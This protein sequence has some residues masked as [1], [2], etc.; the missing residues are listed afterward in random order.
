M[1]QPSAQRAVKKDLRIALLNRI[2]DRSHRIRIVLLDRQ[3]QDRD[4]RRQR[5]GIGIKIPNQQLRPHASLLRVLI[6]LVAGNDPVRVL[7]SVQRRSSSAG[8]NGT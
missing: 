3:I 1:I 4:I 5:A 8:N 7:Y 2:A 6:A